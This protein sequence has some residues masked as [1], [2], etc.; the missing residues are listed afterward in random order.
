MLVL[1]WGTGTGGKSREGGNSGSATI[2][3]KQH[4][5]T[6]IFWT[7]KWL[8]LIFILV[9]LKKWPSPKIFRFFEI[10][11]F[12][13]HYVTTVSLH[14]WNLHKNAK[15]LD[16][17]MNII[18]EQK[19]SCL[20]SAEVLDHFDPFILISASSGWKNFEPNEMAC[21]STF[22]VRETNLLDTFFLMCS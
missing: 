4:M 22:R 3:T 7:W 9:N 10:T 2:R 14:L 5:F 17:H 12:Y 21:Q 18:Q 1:V 6:I 19:L 13:V 20:F 8:L 15:I 16:I 11:F